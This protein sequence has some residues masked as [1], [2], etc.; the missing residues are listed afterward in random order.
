VPEQHQRLAP[1]ARSL[2]PF[3]ELKL[4]LNNT[5]RIT[6]DSIIDITELPPIKILIT[7]RVPRLMRQELRVRPCMTLL[8]K[9]IQG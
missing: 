4:A 9:V 6:K 8:L 7:H 1:I 2:D 5:E 3:K